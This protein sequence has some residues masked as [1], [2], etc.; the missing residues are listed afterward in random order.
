MNLTVELPVIFQFLK[1]SSINFAKLSPASTQESC[2]E[3]SYFLISGPP[4][5]PATRLF[6]SKTEKNCSKWDKIKRKFV[7]NSKRTETYKDRKTTRRCEPK[8]SLKYSLNLM[9]Q[10]DQRELRFFFCSVLR[11]KCI[12]D[13]RT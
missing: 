3:V 12:L 4:A 13:A 8:I 1:I 5:C 7:V 10:G 9:V 6:W 2:A 11:L